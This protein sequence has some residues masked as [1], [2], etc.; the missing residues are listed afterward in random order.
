MR[1]AYIAILGPSWEMLLFY[2]HHI[3][4]SQLDSITELDSGL[5][6]SIFPAIL[7]RENCKATPT[8]LLDGSHDAGGRATSKPRN[9]SII[10]VIKNS[11]YHSKTNKRNIKI[12][13]IS[14][15]LHAMKS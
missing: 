13:K 11:T 6:Y 5:L 1:I 7:W 2:V 8:I 15:T 4:A 12:Y 14:I 3:P 10:L 9:Y